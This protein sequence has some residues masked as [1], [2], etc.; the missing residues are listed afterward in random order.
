MTFAQWIM[1]NHELCTLLKGGQQ[2]LT[3]EDVA[4]REPHQFILKLKGLNYLKP[5]AG[6]VVV[7]C[8]QWH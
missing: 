5:L 3:S 1:G 7:E 6:S 8:A 4:F 2:G